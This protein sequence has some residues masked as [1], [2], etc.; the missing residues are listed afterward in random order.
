MNPTC[1][2][3]LLSEIA[4]LRDEFNTKLNLVI[5]KYTKPNKPE[6]EK[7]PP[8]ITEEQ[9]Q[10]SPEPYHSIGL[11]AIQIADLG[12]NAKALYTKIWDMCL[13][14]FKILSDDEPAL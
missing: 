3:A 8:A 4:A 7:E 13:T 6:P 12:V 5:G 11:A 14:S 9:V 1:N 2:T 10:P